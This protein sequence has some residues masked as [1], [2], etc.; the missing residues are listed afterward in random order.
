MKTIPNVREAMMDDNVALERAEKLEAHRKAFGSLDN[1]CDTLSKGGPGS[2]P[3]VGG[4]A[5]EAE[6]SQSKDS[7][8][9]KLKEGDDV[10]VSSKITGVGGKTVRVVGFSSGGFISVKD[11]EGQ[12]YSVHS[13]DVTL[14][15][16]TPTDLTKGGEGSGRRTGEEM[17]Q[18]SEQAMGDTKLALA[19]SAA[20]NEATG[21]HEK[22]ADG[23][24]QGHAAMMHSHAAD[25]HDTAAESNAK[26]GMAGRDT[27]NYHKTA[28]ALHRDRANELSAK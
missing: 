8:G 23:Q 7:S 16:D 2:G 25:A 12:R 18:R 9:Q 21:R 11:E 13:S 3:R 27:A 14:K 24:L 6:N 1:V 17:G 4:G 20:A 10:K 15:A 5:K 22:A 19:A 28:A 26:S